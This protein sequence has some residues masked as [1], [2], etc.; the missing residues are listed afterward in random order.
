MP[1]MTRQ[2]TRSGASRG[3]L[4]LGTSGFGYDAWK[5]RFYPRDIK[6]KDMLAW[7]ATRLNSVEIN[8]T[9]R[10]LLSAKAVATWIAATPDTFVFALKAHMRVTHSVKLEDAKK[11]ALLFAQ[12]AAP[13]GV[14]T[15]PVLVILP[16][17]IETDRDA[18]AAYLDML[19]P[20]LRYAIEFEHATWDEVRPLVEGRGM[21]RCVSDT[22]ETAAPDDAV[23][24][25]PFAY[26]R[27]RRTEYS[28]KDLA[29]W[30]KRIGAALAAGRDV[31]C[32]FRHED[33]ASGPRFAE[34]LA[35][36]LAKATA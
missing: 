1:P 3:R 36:A 25:G 19:P 30:A 2:T 26:L 14:R 22:D 32:Y 11:A 27:L 6:S 21:G 4:F 15:G 24:S 7:Y 28:A 10:S 35:A 31:H 23:A 12:A 33:T 18:L 9:F 16:K 8:Y 13:L 29:R 17:R 20:G 34:M 5:G